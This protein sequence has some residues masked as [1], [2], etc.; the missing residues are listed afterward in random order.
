MKAT[1]NAQRRMMQAMLSGDIR[2]EGD[3]GFLQRVSDIMDMGLPTLD[4]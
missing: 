3:M 1:A 2:I 4:R